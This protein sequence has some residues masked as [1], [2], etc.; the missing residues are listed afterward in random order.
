[1]DDVDGILARYEERGAARYD[2]AVSQVEHALQCAALAER[3]G[4]ADELVAAALLHDLGHLLEPDGGAARAR[5]R[6][7]EDLYH[8][9]LGARRLEPVFG[10][11][12]SGPVA[13]HVRAKRYLCAVDRSYHDT[14]SPGSVH[15]LVLQG[16]SLDAGQVAA[17]E[18]HPGWSDAV[19]L[20]RWDDLA[21]VPGAP[22][23]QL[24]DYRDLLVDLAGR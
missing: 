1:M 23:R 11:A 13:L 4:A 22:T 6:S 7:T 16:G 2:E 15:S 8:E 19:E 24:A 5:G 3:A 9:A 18:G 12:V 14:L 10:P 20:R 21:K 17:F